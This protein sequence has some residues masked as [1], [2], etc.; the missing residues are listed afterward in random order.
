MLLTPHILAGA[1]IITKVQNPVLGLFLVLLSHYFLDCLPHQKEY[2]I[3]N[4]V[5]RRW[6]KSLPDFL[7]V[8]S[9]I[10]FCFWVIFFITDRN[11]VILL[12]IVFA[13]IPDSFT[14]LHHLFPSNKMLQ[15]HQKI[16]CAINNFFQNEKISPFWGVASQ[17]LVVFI[18]LFL[19]LQ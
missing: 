2:T 18:A 7:K 6:G 16:H 12:S 3:R 1:A 8:F 14:L 11:P 17:V 13:V 15:G 4:I 5:E 10:I 19:L 9:E